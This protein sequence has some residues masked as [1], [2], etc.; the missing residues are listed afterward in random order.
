[1]RSLFDRIFNV[2]G[3]SGS[4]KDAKSRLK[5]LLV[6]DQVDLTPNQMEKMRAEIMEVIAR[7]AEVDPEHVDIRLERAEDKVNVVSSVA[8]RRVSA[9]AAT[10]TG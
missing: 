4:A 10:V 8:V 2:R 7:Y 1:M 9:R 6:H 5:V 3:G